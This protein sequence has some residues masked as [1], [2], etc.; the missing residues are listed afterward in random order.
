MDELIEMDPFLFYSSR[1]RYRPTTKHLFLT[2]RPPLV[3]YHP[4][5]L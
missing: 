5:K 1:S 3:V 4:V 2:S